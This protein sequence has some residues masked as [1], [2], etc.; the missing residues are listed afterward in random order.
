[1]SKRKYFIN[2]DE[3]LKLEK[4]EYIYI[5]GYIWADGYIYNIKNKY[6]IELYTS[7]DSV[8]IKKIIMKTGKW[9]IK[10]RIKYL[11]KT[12]KF[13]ENYTFTV[14][15]KKI[16]NF[17]IDLDFNKKSYISPYKILN[18]IPHNLKHHFYRG[19]SD[20]DGSFSLYNNEKT[21]KYGLTS[22]L[23]QDWHHIEKLFKYLKINIYKIYKYKRK[24][25]NFTYVSISNKSDI[26][27]LGDYLYKNS[28]DIRLERKYDIYQKIKKSNIQKS[29]PKWT[30][31]DINFLKENYYEKGV[32]Y[33]SD[34]LNRTKK[35]IYAKVHK[36][37]KL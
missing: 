12:N 26:I 18:L 31:V 25:G 34:K 5:L 33:C 35:S 37:T 11:K 16:N 19:Y 22:S 9:C 14:S 36:L 20:G 32:N 2:A 6:N 15:D 4:P 24:T 13:Y 30:N 7:K 3:F 1:M 21:C 28:Y 17:L 10:K 8:N 29:S 27:K 23:E